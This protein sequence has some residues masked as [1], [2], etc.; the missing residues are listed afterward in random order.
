MSVIPSAQRPRQ[1]GGIVVGAG[2]P[3][4]CLALAGTARAQSAQQAPTASG[5]GLPVVVVTATRTPLA[6]AQVPA[7]IA[8]ITSDAVH[9]MQLGVNLSE[10]A[11]AVPGLVA[12]DRQN[13][14]Q[15]EQVQIRGFGARSSFGLRGIRVYV[16]GI[17]ATLPD[18]QGWVSNLD[19]GSVDRIEV[20]RGPYS[21]LYGNSSG[22]VIQAFTQPGTGSPVV[23]PGFA[24][25]SNGEVRESTRLAGANGAVGYDVDLTHFQTDGYRDHSAAVRNF[26]NVRLDFPV[27][28]QARMTFVL[29]SVASPIA[30][31]PLGLTRAQFAA[32]PRTVDAAAI[33]YDTRKTFDQT[34]A[35]IAY[36]RRVDADDDL[37]FHLYSGDR[38]AEQFQAITVKAQPPGSPG[39]VID[40]GRSFTG[41]DLHWT[42]RMAVDAAPLTVTAGLT[43]DSLDEVRTGRLNYIGSA[44]DPTLGVAGALRRNQF[45][46]V[47]DRDEY[48]QAL[49]QFMPAWSAMVGVRHSGV[50]FGSTDEPAGIYKT[51]VSSYAPYGATLPV[52]GLGYEWNPATHLYANAGKGFETPTLN[53]L[54]YRP[55]ALRGLNFGLQPDHSRNYEAGIKTRIA[56]LGDI[57][58]AAFRIDTTDEIVTQSNSGGHAVYQ[59][60]GGTKRDGLELGW[61]SRWDKGWQ[62]QLAYTYLNAVYRDAFLTCLTTPC[63]A[64]N[65]QVVAGNRIPGIA[66]STAYAAYGWRPPTGWQAGVDMHAASAVYAD[67]INSQA[68][69]GYAIVGLRVGYS[70]LIGRWNLN[71][72]A[73]ADNLLARQYAGSVI[74]DETSLRFFEPAP[75][76][77]GLFGASGAYSF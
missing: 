57:D 36:E 69:P 58:A 73:R 39:A 45:N 30:Q 77:T 1:R 21:A 74:V 54:A 29:N 59:N 19:L 47:R 44:K 67:D 20:L 13:Y 25:G 68:A 76:R 22:G 31:D 7:S 70:A 14:A 50:D 2:L 40:L 65:R 46:T 11:A 28:P 18:G 60:A 17:P 51:T 66:R 12:R 62:A 41:G 53:E 52:L 56:G 42:R 23:T 35:G 43:Y 8:V 15:D 9:D 33:L 38:N 26:A 61:Q 49:W 24:A 4:L 16:D 34:Q 3:L 64:P 32:A 37:S 48:L 55:D 10:S 6:P 5:D 71:A 63:P 27:D 75:G 72:F